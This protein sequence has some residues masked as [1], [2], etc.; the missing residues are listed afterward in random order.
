MLARRTPG[1]FLPLIFALAIMGWSAMGCTSVTARSGAASN[2]TPT[3][4]IA[5]DA[6][7]TLDGVEVGFTEE[8]YPYRGDAD[9]PLVMVEY[10]DYLCPY[11][12]RHGTQTAPA[13]VEHYVRSSQVKWIFRD[14]PIAGLHPTAAQGHM[15]AQCVAEQ[16]AALFW[17]MHDRLLATQAQ[18]NQL[19]DP[20]AFLAE[21]AK[22]LG[23]DMDAY[24][25]CL[26]SG[27]AAAAVD[28]GIADGQ[29]LGFSGTPSFQFTSQ[30][31]GDAYT[32][33]GAQ[34]IDTFNQWI[35]ALLAGQA[36]P[37]PTPE[38][39]KKPEL[40]FWAKP[41]G[42]APDPARPGFTMAGDAYRGNPKAQVVVVEF[43]NFQCEPCARHALEIQPEL[44]KQFVDKGDV[45][46]VFKNLPLKEDRQAPAAAAAAEC[47]GEQDRFWEMHD[48][49]F[50]KRP[51]WAVE[52]PDAALITLAQEAQLDAGKFAACLQGREG[53]ERVLADLY[54]AQGVATVTPT[55]VILYDGQG[56]LVRGTQPVEKFATILQASLE[57]AGTK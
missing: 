39:A 48:L 31:G 17:R 26:S 55:F 18:W 7:G 5:A 21:T 34:S 29:A 22:G 28:K 52:N 6:P 23:A 44:N 56:T 41:E 25:T 10:S 2:N 49:L 43:S 42:L 16:G 36:P 53:L 4:T 27:R 40:P 8:G 14:F 50:A 15:A 19:P 1:R 9:A 13:L 11:S 47:A 30:K 35:D 24:S 46:W 12:A 38:E 45:L 37:Q 3:G 54:D 32:L 20:A 33:V 57:Q 51:Q